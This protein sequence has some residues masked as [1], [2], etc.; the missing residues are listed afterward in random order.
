MSWSPAV[1]FDDAVTYVQSL[2]KVPESEDVTSLVEKLVV[3]SLF[4]QGSLGPCISKRPGMMHP[5]DR[6]KH[7]AY[8]GLGDMSKEEAKRHYVEILA[9]KVLVEY[10]TPKGKEDTD[11]KLAGDSPPL[12]LCA[13]F[14]A[15]NKKNK[16]DATTGG[17]EGEDPI[18][19]SWSE[20][21]EAAA[22]TNETRKQLSSTDSVI[23]HG[24]YNQVMFGDNTFPAPGKMSALAAGVSSSLVVLTKPE[25][26]AWSSVKGKSQEEAIEEYCCKVEA[27]KE[28]LG[29]GSCEPAGASA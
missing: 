28:R 17:S 4:K 13:L 11:N 7:D 15:V 20:F 14:N 18:P 21:A 6:A 12:F 29:I 24:L 23:L 5:T 27:I 26:E 16:T 19:S 9:L 2:P 25:L 1:L 22:W 3:Y 8:K 10:R